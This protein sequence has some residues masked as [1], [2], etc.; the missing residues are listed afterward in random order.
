MFND[1]VSASA[2]LKV[3]PMGLTHVDALSAP[4][5]HCRSVGV[6][7]S[8]IEDEKLVGSALSRQASQGSSTE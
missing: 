2:R 1:K 7:Y 8:P 4:Y 5:A 6:L 3:L